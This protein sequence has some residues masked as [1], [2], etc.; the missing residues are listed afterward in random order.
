MRKLQLDEG[1]RGMACETC[2]GPTTLPYP[3]AAGSCA[4]TEPGLFSSAYCTSCGGLTFNKKLLTDMFFDAALN[5]VK[6]TLSTRGNGEHPRAQEIFVDGMVTDISAA[7]S[8][9]IESP[10]P[11]A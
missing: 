8:F 5:L 1:F 10:E 9:F 11:G 2:G 6:H 4:C 7:K 3:T